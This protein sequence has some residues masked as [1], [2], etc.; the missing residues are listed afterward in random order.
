[1]ALTITE[2]IKETQKFDAPVIDRS[3]FL[4]KFEETPKITYMRGVDMVVVS[5]RVVGA[6]QKK[7]KTKRAV[8]SVL[9]RFLRISNTSIIDEKVGGPVGMTGDTPI[10]VSCSCP[11][12]RFNCW[13][14]N[15]KEKAH[16]TK[17]KAPYVKVAGS[18]R[19]P[20]N[21]KDIP[22]LCKHIIFTLEYLAI[23]KVIKNF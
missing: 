4:F 11:Y 12:Y 17:E 20:K 10:Q 5:A 19:P 3:E 23:N 8:Y 16:S 21:P 6:P 9:I 13:W 15:H 14:A 2:F 18:N 1:M 22:C 7:K